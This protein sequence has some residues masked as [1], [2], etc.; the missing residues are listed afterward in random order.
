MDWITFMEKK[1]AELMNTGHIM[2][3][4]TFITHLLNSLP[5]TEYEGAILVIKDKLRKGPVEI[6]EI[7]QVLEDKYQAMKHVKGWEE[8]EEDYALFASPPNKKGT[9]KAFKGR[10]G[11]CGEFGHKAA[12]CPNKK[13]NQN[14]GQKPKNQQKK[15]QQ[16]KGD[17][18][19]KGFIDMSKIKCFNCEEFGHFALDCPKARDNANIAQESEQK[20]K[21]ESMLDLDNS[22]VREECAMVCTE[23]QYKDTSEDDVVY[24]DQGINTEEYEKATY[25]NLMK[26]QSEEEKRLSALLPNELTIV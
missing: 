20:G 15:T 21:S 26:T 7:E 13:S 24:G 25:G 8:E 5:Q 17:S 18:N 10:C 2:N 1:R 22:S 6:P 4:E 9:K 12:D 11:Y 3:D 19:G 14:K 16:G 23:L